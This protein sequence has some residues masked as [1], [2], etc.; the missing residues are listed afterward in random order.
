MN[1]L[2]KLLLSCSLEQIMYF[3]GCKGRATFIW[4]AG[5]EK[6]GSDWHSGFDYSKN[7]CLNNG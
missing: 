2:I 3:I 1:K 7:Y 6:L 5:V 4:G